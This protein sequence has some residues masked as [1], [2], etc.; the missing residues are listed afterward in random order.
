MAEDPFPMIAT[1][2]PVQSRDW[3]HAAVCISFPLKECR[4]LMSGQRHL[5]R[6]PD[7]LINTSASSSTVVSFF[8][9]LIFHFPVKS[10]QIVET[11]LLF[12]STCSSRAYLCVV[13]L[14]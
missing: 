2:L 9:T 7:P 11:T 6:M 5:L 8:W 4:P 10:S 14:I 1:R 3:S 13:L 12:N